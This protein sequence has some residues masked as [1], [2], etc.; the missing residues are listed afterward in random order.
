MRRV[1]LIPINKGKGTYTNDDDYFVV[2]DYKESSSTGDVPDATD[3]LKGIMKLYE[4]LGIG[5][6]GTIHRTAITAA[7][8]KRYCVFAS[9]TVP[10]V[11]NNATSETIIEELEIT[12]NMWRNQTSLRLQTMNILGVTA[13][14]TKRFQ[15]RISA[16]SGVLGTL[17][18]RFNT[19]A[20]SS[21]GIPFA[22]SCSVYDDKIN[23]NVV[24]TTSLLDNEGGNP[25][26]GN[27]EIAIDMSA[28][29]F[30]QFTISMPNNT[31]TLTTQDFKCLGLY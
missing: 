29:I 5:I 14:G 21:V 12:P 20:I 11:T 18:A 23:T 2:S 25:G 13:A 31:D 27:P 16:T 7:F 19:T 28:S 24:A 17:L 9:A 3:S 6:D 1:V 26:G 22:R 4:S 8:N 10:I 30:V 15:F